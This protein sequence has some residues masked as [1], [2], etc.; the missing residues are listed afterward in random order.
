MIFL[1]LVFI[2]LNILIVCFYLKF[3]SDSFSGIHGIFLPLGKF[4]VGKAKIFERI[5]PDDTKCRALNINKK[6]CIEKAVVKSIEAVYVFLIFSIIII[7]KDTYITDNKISRPGYEEKDKNMDINFETDDEKGSFNININK[8]IYDKNYIQEHREEIRGNIQKKLLEDNKDLHNIK[9]SLNFFTAYPSIGAY[10][11]WEYDSNLFDIDGKPKL[12]LEKDIHTFIKARVETESGFEFSEEYDIII[13]KGNKIGGGIKNYL[14]EDDEYVYLP[15][16]VAGKKIDWK[17]AVGES[18]FKYMIIGCILF[19]GVSFITFK[20]ID[21]KYNQ[22]LLA[23]QKEYPYLISVL[24]LYMETGLSLSQ[25]WLH[26]CKTYEGNNSEVSQELAKTVNNIKTGKSIDVVFSDFASSCNLKEYRKLS[27][28]IT[29][30]IRRGSASILD[31][32]RQ[33]MI[34]LEKDKMNF[35]KILAKKAETK[36]LIPLMIMLILVFIIILAPSILSFR[37]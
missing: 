24:I 32:L 21:E 22:R 14:K 13:P 37:I 7:S 17:S 4:I 15:D 18:P 35:A 28:L 8:K 29:Q 6:N 27:Q 30:N 20:K 34:M 31:L 19:L 16:Q 12:N 9:T 11:N 2:T 5:S 23:L 26:L 36:L 33:E 25:A 3:K 1:I 10:I